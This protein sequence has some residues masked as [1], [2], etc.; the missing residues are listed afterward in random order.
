[1]VDCLPAY[2]VVLGMLFMV[3]LLVVTSTASQAM[4]FPTPIGIEIVTSS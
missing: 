4:K 2:N 1:M 3:D